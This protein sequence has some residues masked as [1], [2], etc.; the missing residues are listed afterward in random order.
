MREDRTAI[1]T[2]SISGSGLRIADAFAMSSTNVMIS[3]FDEPKE[4]EA[5]LT[6]PAGRTRSHPDWIKEQTGSRP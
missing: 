3:G 4:F 5:V 1:V 2:G 6:L